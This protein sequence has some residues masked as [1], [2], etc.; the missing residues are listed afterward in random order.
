MA[1][2]FIG[3]GSNI[4]D[5]KENI[6]KAIKLLGKEGCKIEK[7]SKIIETVPVG[8]PPQPKFLNAAIKIKTDLSP[9]RLLNKL[10][11]IEKVM[12]RKRTVRWGP[13]IIDLDILLYDKLTLKTKKLTIPHPRMWQREFVLK[14]LS[15]LVSLNKLKN[16]PR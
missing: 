11:K 15:S 5:R 3:I 1:R 6:K 12:G 16:S 4:G 10:K 2:V 13:R 14:P 8:G 7:I 9:P